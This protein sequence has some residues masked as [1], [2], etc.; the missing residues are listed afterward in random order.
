MTLHVTD[1][2]FGGKTI[3]L[4]LAQLARS[5]TVVLTDRDTE[6]LTTP[7]FE[8]YLGDRGFHLPQGN[9]KCLVTDSASRLSPPKLTHDQGFD[10]PESN[11]TTCT[12]I[13][14]ERPKAAKTAKGEESTFV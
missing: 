13:K 14:E 1:G 6:P 8:A 5:G 4:Q 10:S 7:E 11:P 9:S 12:H 2:Y 3:S